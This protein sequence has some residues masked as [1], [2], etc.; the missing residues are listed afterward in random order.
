MLRCQKSKFSLQEGVSYLNC[1]YMGPL[2][3]RSEEA[4][5]AGLQRKSNPFDIRPDDFF[6]GTEELK[7]A[8]AELINCAEPQRIV[9][10]PSV[11]YGMANVAA[12]VPLQAGQN[13]IVSEEQFPSNI[14]TWQKAAASKGAYLKVVQAP[15]D[16]EGRGKLWNEEIL[17]AIDENTAAVCLAHVHWADGTKFN[18]KAIGEKARAHGAWLIIDGTQSVGALP[19]DTEEIQPDALVCGA[20]KWLLGG[21]SFALCYYGKNMDEGRPIEENWMNRAGSENFRN[22]INYES[23]YKPFGQRYAVGEQSNFV[24]TPIAL[25]ALQQIKEWTPA[26]IQAYCARLTKEPL[27]ILKALGCTIENS[28][29]RGEHLLGIYLP[30]H[31]KTEDLQAKFAEKKIFVSLRGDAIRISP[32]VYN[33][34]NDFERFLSCFE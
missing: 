33:D 13:I 8:Y 17:N 34:G 18:L 10:A 19:F 11:S 15:A 29:Y 14:Y 7:K 28:K 21:Y 24:N 3:K 1:A 31:F 4:G 27:E 2:L 30:E 16:F 12:N 23:R 9:V 22:L 26:G 5:I 25:T 32:H 6:S 20:Y